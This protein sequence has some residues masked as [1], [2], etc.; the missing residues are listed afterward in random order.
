MLIAIAHRQGRT[1]IKFLIHRPRAHQTKS[2]EVFMM[3]AFPTTQQM[4][5]GKGK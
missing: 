3:F 2:V 5:R 1:L 4:K